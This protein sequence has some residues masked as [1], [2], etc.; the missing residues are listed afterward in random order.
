MVTWKSL[1]TDRYKNGKKLP[2]GARIG[3]KLSRV[4]RK[5]IFQAVVLVI[6][7]ARPGLVTLI[8]HF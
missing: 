5:P 7:F 1:K 4:I 3:G 6:I 2:G 8:P